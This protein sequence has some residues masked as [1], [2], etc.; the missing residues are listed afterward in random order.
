MFN[1][2]SN[3]A[4]LVNSRPELEPKVYLIA[5]HILCYFQWPQGNT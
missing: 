4:Q 2:L 3:V 5:K 1:K